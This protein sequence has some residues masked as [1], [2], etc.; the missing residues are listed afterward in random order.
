MQFLKISKQEFK[1]NDMASPKQLAVR[2]CYDVIPAL[3]GTFAFL[4]VTILKYLNISVMAG[5]PKAAF[6]IVDA[7]D[8][9]GADEI[10]QEQWTVASLSAALPN[11]ELVMVWLARRRLIA[12]T[13][14]CNV[15]QQPCTL[16]KRSDIQDGYRYFKI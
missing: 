13:V 9:F 6:K 16:V 2:T 3:S 14:P 1:I 11:K 5:R 10:K 4:V 7:T 12:N 15:C 8:I